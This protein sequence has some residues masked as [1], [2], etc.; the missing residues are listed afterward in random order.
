MAV[1]TGLGLD[2]DAQARRDAVA[3]ARKSLLGL[4]DGLIARG[5]ATAAEIEQALAAWDQWGGDPDNVYLRCRC[6][7]GARRM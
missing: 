3:D 1:V 7:C 2:Y 4:R 5:L 6:E